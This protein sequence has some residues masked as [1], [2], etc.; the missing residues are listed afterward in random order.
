MGKNSWKGKTNHKKSGSGA[1]SRTELASRAGTGARVQAGATAKKNSDSKTAPV[2]VGQTYSIPIDGLGSSGEGVG[3]VDH[4]TVFVPFSLPGETVKARITQVKKSYATGRLIEVESPSAHRIDPLCPVY[5]TCGGC[6]LQ[7]VDYEEQLNLKTRMVQDMVARIGKADPAIV[8]PAIGPET[9]WQYRN[10]MQLPVGGTRENVQMGFY[11]MGSHHIVPVTDCA[12]QMEGNNEIAKACYEI[13]RDLKIEP[14]DE[15][16]GTGVLRHVIGRVAKSK[17]SE[18]IRQG[19]QSE[20]RAQ[21][22]EG[23]KSKQGE[24]KS[25]MGGK[26]QESAEEEW[27]V[28]LVT[29]TEELPRSEGWI[30]HLTRRFPQIRSIIH[31]Y[32][33]K[34]TNVIMGPES[35]VL[36]GKEQIEDKIKDLQFSLSGHSFFQVNPAQTAVLYDKALEYAGLQGEE[37]VIDAYCGTGTISLFLAHQAKKVIGIE[38]VEAAIADAKENAKRNGFTNTRFIA[39]DAA[40]EMPR[41]YKAGVR[42][43]VIVFDPVRAGCKEPVLTAAAIMEPKRMVYV[44]CNPASMARD[45]VVLRSYGYEAVKIQPVD[46]FPQTSHVECVCLIIRN[47]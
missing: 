30:N 32:N 35:K 15:T 40:E 31:N 16:T 19:K 2:A 27:M 3:R 43:D 28:I 25:V 20:H 41:L 5:G 22:N 9:P 24:E 6:Q 11:A 34:R 1:E 8:L 17:Q 18:E 7:H 42:P 26:E 39:G 23:E 14:Y 45:L 47:K 4:F 29:A 46:M 12:I 10:K 36:W 37:T 13:A 21:G 44:S 38:I 33:P